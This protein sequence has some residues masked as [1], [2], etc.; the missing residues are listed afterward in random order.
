MKIYNFLAF[1]LG[2]TSGRSVVGTMRDG[3]LETRE[4][5]RFPNSMVELHGKYY[6][7]LL[8]LYEHL[9]EGL[10]AAVREGITPDS[11]GIDTWGVDVVPV[12][13]DGSILAMPRAYRDPYTDG[14]PEAY[15]EIIPREVVY[16]KT[17]IQIMN[18]NTLFQIFAAIKEGYKAY[19]QKIFTLAGMEEAQAVKAMEATLAI[20]DQI[21]KIS[22]S[23]VVLRDM[24]ANYY[25][26]P[27][28]ELAKQYGQTDWE[29]YFKILGMEAPATIIVG[30]PEVL[31]LVNNLLK[32]APMEQI[33]Y[34]IAAHYL[35]SATSHLND[36]FYAASFDFYGRQMSGA[37]EPRPRWKR[38]MAATD[39]TFDMAVG[40]MYVEKYFS[41]QDKEKMTQLVKNLQEALGQHIDALEWMSDETKGR[42]HEKL[43]TFKVKEL[44]RANTESTEQGTGPLQ[45]TRQGRAEGGMGVFDAGKLL[46]S[47]SLA[48]RSL[49]TVFGRGHISA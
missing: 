31:A 40:K 22:R 21:A 1:D 11:I 47:R 41:E 37:Q 16:D 20:E 13:E 45:L 15:F 6:W 14:A 7:N 18:F 42:A 49:L 26:T 5:T 3:K 33:R 35:N 17:G 32:T 9:K 27:Y 38:A 30:Q 12:A 43:A 34:Y 24:G 36:E 8:G 25:A 23:S 28:E 19:L 39:A 2:A 48:G 44:G 10:S 46:L 4:L 29:A